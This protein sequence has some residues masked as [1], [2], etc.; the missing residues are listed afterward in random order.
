MVISNNE[1]KS[2]YSRSLLKLASRLNAQGTRVGEMSILGKILCF[3]AEP[4]RWLNIFQGIEDFSYP[5]TW[6][7][8]ELFPEP[9]DIIHCHNLHGDYFDLRA[10]SW[11]SQKLP[12]VLTLHDAWLLS[13]HCAHSFDCE[14][15]KTGCGQCPDLT[16]DPAVR[17]DATA[18]N[19]QRK[20]ALY[21]GS[22]L[23][24][25]APSQWLMNKV[26]ESIL[27]TAVAEWRV[28]PYGVDMTVFRPA[29]RQ[30][31]RAAIDIPLSARVLLFTANGIRRNIWKDYKTMKAAIGLVAERLQG[32]DV[33][34]IAL[35]EDAPAERVGRA[36]VRFVPY[37]KDPEAVARYYQAA[38]V[39]LHAARA[40]TFPNTILE[41]LAC[42]TPV[43]ATAVGGIPEQVKRMEQLGESMPWKAYGV[44]EATGFL[45]PQGDE[46]AMAAAIMTLLTDEPLL[47]RLGENATQDARTRFTLEQQ[48]EEYLEW[49]Q[50][51]IEEKSIE[52]LAIEDTRA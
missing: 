51:I 13:G 44:E 43:V 36:E 20:R 19:W 52:C 28:I 2:F 14:R 26:H 9:P 7:L 16:I 38:D 6:R 5:G 34:F 29:D 11:L 46:K 4:R 35:G 23:Y 48:V 31:V 27:T 37:Q 45:V 25:V 21:A 32:Q 42:G 1:A 39:Y 41:A 8:L 24:V 15:W 3:F 18:F 22:R 33:C 50:A 12:V 17:R 10:I 30:E 40:D 49:Y 47:E